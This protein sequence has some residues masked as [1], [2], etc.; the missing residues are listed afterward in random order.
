MRIY[1]NG[2]KCPCCGSVLHGKTDAWLQ[3]FSALVDML[4]L[5]PWEEP[6]QPQPIQPQELMERAGKIWRRQLGGEASA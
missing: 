2:D 4:R 3:D 1:Q 6:P 5:P